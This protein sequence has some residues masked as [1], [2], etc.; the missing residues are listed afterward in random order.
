MGKIVFECETV[1]PLFMYGADGKTPELRPASIKGLMRFWWRAVNGDSDIERLKEAEN[2]IF[3]STDR[4]SSFS[5][6]VSNSNLEIGSFNPLPNKD[7][8]M[9]GFKPNQTFEIEFF[10]KNLEIIQNIFLILTILGGFGKSAK[11]KNNGKIKVLKIKRNK[12]CINYEEIN[13]LNNILKLLGDKFEIV[14]NE[15]ISKNFKFNYPMVHKIWIDNGVLKTKLK[16]D[17]IFQR[18]LNV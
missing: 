10:G 1:T 11:I 4:K 16:E 2:R 5:I 8:K 17:K 7:F 9:K 18:E 13:N 3:G 6:K 12:S 15:I 14:E